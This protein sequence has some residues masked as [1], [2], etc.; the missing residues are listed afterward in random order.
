MQNVAIVG[1]GLIAR[2]HLSSL[3]DVP[4]ATVVALCDRNRDR[5]RELAPLAP[6]AEI[7]SDLAAALAEQHIDVVH[8]LTPPGSHAAIAIEAAEAGCHVLVE[9]P[10]ALDVAEADAMIAAGEAAGVVV[11]PNHNYL[12][13]P[14]VARA[15]E[16]VA[17]GA[18][19]EVVAVNSFYGVAGEKSSYGGSGAR[20]HWAWGL[21]GGVFTNFLP[22]LIYLQLEFLGGIDDVV[23]AAYGGDGADPT[24]LTALLR[25]GGATGTMTVSLRTKPY[26][27]YVE[28]FGTNGIVHADLVRETTYVHRDRR[29]PSIVAKVAHNAGLAGQIAA[30]TVSTS[31]Q[32]ATG[33]MKRMPELRVVIGDLYASLDGGG[34]PPTSAAQGREVAQVLESIRHRLPAPAPAPAPPPLPTQPTS[35]AERRFRDAMAS[36]DV[37]VTGA[38]GFL[39]GRL[40]EALV[41]CGVRPV[42]LLRNPNSVSPALAEH[43]RIVAGDVRDPAALADAAKGC[44]VVFHCAAVTTNK[45]PAAVHEE[46]NVEGS[47]LVVRAAGAARARRVIHCSSVIVYGVAPEAPVVTEDTALDR[48]AGRWDHYLRT[49]VA[50][51]D[52]VRDEAAHLDDLDLVVLRLGILHGPGHAP[53]PAVVSLGRLQVLMG[54][55]RNVL[56]YTHVDDA[57]DAMLLAAA[58]PEA[59]GNAF[60][61][62][63][64]VS[65]P[66]RAVARLVADPD[67]AGA[68]ARVIGL[69]RLALL[70]GAR[71]LERRAAAD[72]TDTPPR[73]SG[74]VVRSATRDVRYASTKARRT[75]GWMPSRPLEHSLRR[76]AHG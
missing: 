3:A 30:Q 41:R 64:D 13:K 44:S 2:A 70:A 68:G 67:G 29:L 8:V 23:G 57:V 72:G 61:I 6:R 51:E 58:V 12:F 27:K 10:M 63:G 47:R 74:F 60:N 53:D 19:G 7:Y 49:K 26:M 18:I 24:E 75:L 54:S 42:L 71:N 21:P 56:P 9:K 46:I 38:S 4:T 59:G 16:L 35:D 66:V 1:C 73:L 52:A 20:S 50:A 11:A 15:R 40:A 43:A 36:D 22:H 14:S 5:A 34:A 31:A 45:A 39:G 32:V 37:L 62:V 69:P 28:V 25:R 55:G 33:R 65:A 76:D 17:S 48:A